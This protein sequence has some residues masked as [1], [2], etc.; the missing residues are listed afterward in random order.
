[1]TLEELSCAEVSDLADTVAAEE[2]AGANVEK[3][4]PAVL[5]HLRL[6]DRCRA[7]YLMLL[8]ALRCQGEAASLS[9][10]L[11]TPS[12]FSSL[13]V[14]DRSPWRRLTGY[15]AS[16]LPLTFEIEHSYIERALS[17]P[18]LTGVRG[19]PLTYGEQEVLLLADWVATKHGD[20]MVELTARRR[21][22]H[23]QAV[24][25]EARL[26]TSD[27]MP[28]GLRASISWGNQSH[29]A[30]LD[31]EGA[32]TFRDLSLRGLVEPES[33]CIKDDLTIS[34]GVEHTNHGDKD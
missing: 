17:G 34:F 23:P 11:Y 2:L 7:A 12:S 15:A 27:P 18:G 9:A 20:W 30:P 29:S 4:Y 6:C 28:A 26:A 10:T 31:P 14:K 22:S 19:E 32:A 33:G 24:D 16:P 5:A 3:R 21:P 1:M 8:D 25:L 13:D